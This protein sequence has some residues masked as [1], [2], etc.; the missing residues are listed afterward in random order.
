M[1]IIFDAIGASDELGAKVLETAEARSSLYFINRP[2]D[3][4]DVFCT[5]FHHACYLNGIHL[6]STVRDT[7]SNRDLQERCL[8]TLSLIAIYRSGVFAFRIV[9]HDC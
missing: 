2:Y 7:F 6:C 5:V 4:P 1:V 8:R 3:R 9:K